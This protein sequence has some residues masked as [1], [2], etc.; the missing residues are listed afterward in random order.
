LE[1]IDSYVKSFESADADL[2]QSLFWFDDPRFVEVENHIREPFGRERFLYI[3]DWIRKYQKPWW[4][5]RFYDTKVFLL[6]PSVAYTISMRE[7]VEDGETSTSRVTLI[8]LKKD[9]V[10]KIIHGHFSYKPE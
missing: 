3:M 5:M 4:K 7:T 2:M 1:I 9:G 6:S 10:W 8:F